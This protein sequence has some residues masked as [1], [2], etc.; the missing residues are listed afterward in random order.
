[1]GGFATCLE[2]FPL[3]TNSGFSNSDGK[4][5][6]VNTSPNINLKQDGSWAIYSSL[7]TFKSNRRHTKLKHVNGNWW[8]FPFCWTACDVFYFKAHA[9]LIKNFQSA[10][11]EICLGRTHVPWLKCK[12][13]QRAIYTEPSQ[14]IS[15]SELRATVKFLQMIVGKETTSKNDKWLCASYFFD[16]DSW[17]KC[18]A[19][20]KKHTMSSRFCTKTNH[21]GVLSKYAR[22]T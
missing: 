22:P 1:M 6:K 2:T 14:H 16:S 17:K 5:K 12:L 3:S 11:A 20:K 9:L 7:P 18:K 13:G 4:P 10:C 8:L 21:I 19:H 15:W